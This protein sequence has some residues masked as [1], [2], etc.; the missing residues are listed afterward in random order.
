[1]NTSL[2]YDRLIIYYFSG[3]GNAKR[4]ASW[5][6]DKAGQSGINT[7]LI[8]IADK[9][10]QYEFVP[11]ERT[12]IGFCY[13]THGFNAPPIVIRYLL[14][15]PKS[16]RGNVFLLNTRAGMK[17]SKLFMPGLSGLAQL[18]PAMVLLL[19]GYRIKGMQPMDLPSNW[20]SVHPGLKKKVIDSIFKR[21]N[22]ITD[23]FTEHI[24]NGKNIYKGLISLPID[25]LIS[26]IGVAYYFFGRFMIAKTFFASHNCNNC[27]LCIKDCPVSAIKEKYGRP[28]WTFN[29]ESCMKCLNHC[30]QRAIE[31]PHGF[32][33]L[34]WWAAMSFVPIIVF[35]KLKIVFHDF[36]GLSFLMEI[37]YY[38]FL[39]MAI[40]GAYHF[41]HF[42]L[43]FKFFSLLI[44]YT[45]LTKFRF[46]R[47]YKAPAA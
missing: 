2:K 31:T 32:T 1:M 23:Q 44:T 16:D 46:W 28:Y 26:P 20:I 12:L 45:S 19:K 41:L 39:G 21:C 34:V 43:R 24:L 38:I 9:K 22:R 8:N 30:P 5:I 25:L 6:Y 14:K 47:R 37:L 15:F 42:M 13:P 4:A 10:N 33:F 3:T 17:L 7:R 40:W 11:D 18:F 36:Y 35:K 27:G 29:C